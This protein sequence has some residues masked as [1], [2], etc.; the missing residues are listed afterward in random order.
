MNI[1]QNL[2]QTQIQTLKQLLSP[3]MIQMLGTFSLSYS[4]LVDQISEA[5]Q[6][7]VFVEVTQSDE[8]FSMHGIKSSGGSDLD[9]SESVSQGTSLIGFLHDQI[10]L[11]HMGEKDRQILIFLADHLDS[12][13]YIENYP[14][15][16]EEATEHFGIQERKVNDMLKILQSFEPDGVGARSL[17]E[18]LLI[19]VQHYDFDNE[20]LQELLTELIKSHLQN[21][22]NIDIDNIAD[23]MDIEPEGVEALIT[24][25][26]NNLNPNPGLGYS[27]ET[28]NNHIVPSFEVTVE[29]GKIKILNLEERHGIK[30]TISDKYTTLIEDPNTDDETRAFLKQKL[31]AAKTLKES[32]ENRHKNLDALI[33]YVVH[34]QTAFVHH[35][36]LFLEP[37]LQKDI[38]Q[39]LGISPSTVSRIVSS[40]FVRTPHGTLPIKALCPRSHFGKTSERLKLIVSELSEK[41]PNLSD[42][43]LRALL[44][45]DFGLPIARRTVAKYRA[46]SGVKSSYNRS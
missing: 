4:D 41:H 2:S 13:G 17:K 8:L 34:K 46:L 28:N 45:K 38:A 26:R 11:Q 15:V 10:E 29:N 3:K 36:T 40:K 21:F 7:N 23:S 20:Y 24:F 19:Q 25:I 31:E 39:H 12:R 18:C 1:N 44:Q 37:L 43:K 33:H 42:E 5:A 14:E 16:R 9:F 27:N 30:I 32:L 6:E 22:E 35:G